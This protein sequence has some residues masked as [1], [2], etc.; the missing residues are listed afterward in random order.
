MSVQQNTCIT[1]IICVA[2]LYSTTKL[3]T[4][5]APYP[6]QCRRGAGLCRR[7]L[8]LTSKRK[9]SNVDWF[10]LDQGKGRIGCCCV[11]VGSEL[12]PPLGIGRKVVVE[13]RMLSLWLS[14]SGKEVRVRVKVWVKV[15]TR[16]RRECG[17]SVEQM[18]EE[19]K[20]GGGEEWRM[21]V[22]WRVKMTHVRGRWR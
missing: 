8:S 5:T 3:G 7:G 21:E 15:R 19:D 1:A 4:Q 14:G 12:P 11:V 22:R 18:W 17:G 16:V 13:P 2:L 9:L 6:Q 10:C 20:G